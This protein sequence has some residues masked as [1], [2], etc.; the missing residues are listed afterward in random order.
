M[1]AHVAYGLLK[2]ATKIAVIFVAIVTVF[3]LAT[4]RDWGDETAVA[5]GQ[6]PV[7]EQPVEPKRALSSLAASEGVASA[8]L[9]SGMA[10]L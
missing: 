8:A 1:A 3:S 10:G 5:A 9:V 7:I 2:T 6:G 4:D